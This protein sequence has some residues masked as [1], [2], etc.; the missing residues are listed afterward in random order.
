[1]VAAVVAAGVLDHKECRPWSRIRSPGVRWFFCRRGVHRGLKRHG[2]DQ[3]GDQGGRS[4]PTSGGPPA[5]VEEKT[6]LPIG[7][8]QTGPEYYAK[9]G[10]GFVQAAQ[11]PKPR[12]PFA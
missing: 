1:M 12:R 6:T 5:C 10:L 7:P 2:G 8:M 11:I 9:G 3:M 4:P